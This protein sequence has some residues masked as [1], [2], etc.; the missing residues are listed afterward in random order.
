MRE[1]KSSLVSI[2]CFRDLFTAEGYFI[3]KYIIITKYISSEMRNLKYSVVICIGV[4]FTEFK[5]RKVSEHMCYGG[6]ALKSF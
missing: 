2:S 4:V 3:G 1:S 6:R 5:W